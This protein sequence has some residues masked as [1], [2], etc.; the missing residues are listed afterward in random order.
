MVKQ[1]QPNKNKFLHWAI[2]GYAI[3]GLGI[4]MFLSVIMES[5]PSNQQVSIFNTDFGRAVVT[6]DNI[7]LPLNSISNN[8]TFNVQVKLYE[9]DNKIIDVESVKLGTNSSILSVRQQ[10]KSITPIYAMKICDPVNNTLN[11]VFEY[12]GS[13]AAKHPLRVESIQD[14]F[15]LLVSYFTNQ[16]DNKCHI[17]QSAIPIIWNVKTSDWS[18]ITYFQIIFLGVLVS[19][20]F[21]VGRAIVRARQFRINDVDFVWIPFS[22]IITLLI[23]TSFLSQV[24]LSSD[25]ISNFAL[26]FGFGFGFDKV[27]ETWKQ[28]S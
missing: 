20:M 25:I 22:A 4:S 17:T 24:K 7:E 18:K 27:F 14:R 13:F 2:W 10:L 16:T 1:Q 26:A 6:T 3:L 19:R 21:P 12:R 23:F 28:K 11:Q 8:Y 9:S 5:N 15:T